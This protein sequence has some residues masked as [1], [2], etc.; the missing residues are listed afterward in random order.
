MHALDKDLNKLTDSIKKLNEQNEAAAKSGNAFKETLSTL[1]STFSIWKNIIEGVR[2]GFLTFTNILSAGLTILTIYGPEIMEWVAS[3]IQ[4]KDA[5]NDATLKLNAL[6]KAFSSSDYSKAIQQLDELKINVDLARNGFLKK[7]DVLNQYNETLGKTMGKASS[8]AE[9]ENKLTK[10]GPAYIKM[11]LYKAAAQLALQDAAKKAYEA[12]QAKLKSD[13]DSLT[14]WDK[15]MDVLNRNP[16]AAGEGSRGIP[17]TS[18]TADREKKK[19]A[20]NRRAQAV[21][22]AQNE[23]KKLEA[24]AAGF[25]KQAADIAKEMDMSFWDNFDTDTA[26]Q[27]KKQKIDTSRAAQLLQA[28]A[29]TFAKQIEL[30]K[31]HYDIELAALN[32]A[33]SRKLISQEDYD[34]KSEQL[35]QKFHL[36]IGDKIQFFNKN[37]FDEAKKQMQAVIDANQHEDTVAK[38]EKKVDKALLPGQKLEAEK[39]LIDDKYSYEIKLAAG[40]V[41]K[42]KELEDQKQKDITALTQQYEQ[43]RKEFALQSAQQVADKAFSIIQNNIKTQSGARIRGLEKDKSAELSNKNLTNTQKKAIED[44]YQKRKLQKKSRPLRQNRKHRYYKPLLTVHW[45]LPKQRHKR[46]YLLPLLYRASSPLQLY[47]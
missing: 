46:V 33:L 28:R 44:K 35:Q 26:P 31:Q 21:K 23:Q 11:T 16:G 9:V 2:A 17:N 24:I 45:P 14:F 10:D 5:I 38:D 20:E 12:E 39:Q 4:G 36:G 7:K 40:N 43:Q 30:D 19:Q 15:V 25:Q 13:D 27:K 3:L 18:E 47:K 1:S 8:L 22:D 41:D 37:D 6:N 42:I 34:K 29:I 32:D